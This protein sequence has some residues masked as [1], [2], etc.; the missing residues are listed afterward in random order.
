MKV[1]VHSVEALR[2]FNSGIAKDV[3]VSGYYHSGDGGGGWY[4]WQTGTPPE[5]NGG[6]IIAS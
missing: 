3:Y 4:A 2:Y 1:T 5:D 6:T